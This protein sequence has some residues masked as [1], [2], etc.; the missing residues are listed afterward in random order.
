MTRVTAS[1]ARRVILTLITLAAVAPMWARAATFTV[2]SFADATDAKRGDGIC[3]TATGNGVCT[4]R[5]AIM[6]T[7]SLA[8]ADTIQLPAG[9]YVITLPGTLSG[10]DTNGSLDMKDNLTIV[11]AGAATTIVDGGGLDSVFAVLANNKSMSL[12]GLTIQ[13][14][15]VSPFALGGGG[16]L[17]RGQ[18]Q[19]TLTDVV[20]QN[21]QA[22]DGGA[23]YNQGTL[24]LIH[25]IVQGNSATLVATGSPT[26][27]HGGGIYNASTGTVVLQDSTIRDNTSM[28]GGGLFNAG[29][30]DI[31]DSTISGNTATN[32]SVNNGD[33]GG[34]IVNGDTAPATMTITDSTVSGNSANGNYGGIFDANGTLTLNSTTIAANLADADNDGV[35]GGGGLGLSFD[36]GA[37]ALMRN[38]ILAGNSAAGTTPDCINL[39]AAAL[40]SGGHN[41]I[42]NPG[43]A[44]DCAFTATPDDL[45]GTIA[46]PIDPGLKPLADN[47]GPTFTQ[48]LTD[49]SPAI[50]A[51]DPNGCSDGVNMLATDQRGMPRAA[52]GTSGTARCDIGAYEVVRPVANAGADQRVNPGV[53]VTLDASASTAAGGIAS[54]AWTQTAGTAVTLAGADTVSPSFTSPSSA[55]V[56]TFQL[57]VADGSGA[58]SSDSVDIS[59]NAAPLAD[60]GTDQTVDPGTSVNLNGSASSDSDGSIASYA[61]VQTSGTAVTLTGADTATPSFTAPTSG[62]TLVFAL[63]VTDNEGASAT[64]SVTV[65]VNQ[66]A[67]PPST[68]LPPVAKAKARKTARPRSVVI[69]DG[70]RSYDPDGRIVKFHWVQTGGPHVRLFAANWPWAAFVAPRMEGSLTFELTVTDNDGA[71]S[72]DSVTITVGDCVPHWYHRFFHKW[73]HR[74][75]CR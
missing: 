74:R 23:I 31:K 34:G 51:G 35:G 67:P 20:L 21:N 24:T 45:V 17:A 30:A 63:T 43:S 10:G 71:S 26:F 13:N 57:T 70:W 65:T 29:T 14:G 54:Y 36:N 38:T 64:D 75:E 8:G 73:D 56:L 60:A 6:E 15:S 32:V 49:S 12:S 1:F 44:V 3:E 33:G 50:D 11:G 72:S 22:G 27:R 9:T 16:I 18:N 68:N 55:G 61:W 4:L 47:G 69:L 53:V 48:A 2:N 40:T 42:G 46:A 28:T 39:V 62:A 66:P 25:T 19:L 59:V 7:N 52:P 5:A 58:T 37:T 41:L